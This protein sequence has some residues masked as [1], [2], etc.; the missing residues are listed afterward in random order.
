M[1]QCTYF[2]PTEEGLKICHCGYEMEYHTNSYIN[3]SNY[4]K[5]TNLKWEL[6]KH[7][8][9]EETNAFGEIEFDGHEGDM[10]PKFVRVDNNIDMSVIM[11]LMK[12]WG[13]KLPNLLISVAGDINAIPKKSNL[14]DGLMKAARKTDAWIITDGIQVSGMKNVTEPELTLKEN[15]IIGIAPWG[16]IHNRTALES[17]EGSWPAKYGTT[18]TCNS[19]ERFLDPDHS[20]YILVDDGTQHKLDIE[21]PFRMRLEREMV[22]MKTDTGN[23]VLI[24]TVVIGGGKATLRKIEQA[25]KQDTPVVV[26][27]GSG[28]AA[29]VL[30]YA[31]QNASMGD[32]DDSS[33]DGQDRHRNEKYMPKSLED[34]VGEKMKQKDISCKVKVIKSCLLK[35]G[36]IHI[37]DMDSDDYDIND[38]LLKAMM[39]VHRNSTKILRTQI[40]MNNNFTQIGSNII[41][42][43]EIMLNEI[44]FNAI[45]YERAD[46]VNKLI[47]EK[48]ELKTFFLTD[49]KLLKLYNNRRDPCFDLLIWSVLTNQQDKAK[50]FWSH[51]KNKLSA[52]L[53][54]HALFSALSRKTHDQ[55]LREAFDNN[56]SEFMTYA[57]KL[58]NS[59]YN[60]DKKKTYDLL[61][62]IVPEWDNTT[63]IEIAL[64][65][66]NEGFISLKVYRDLFNK[67]WMG[68]L[69]P[70]NS[71]M[72]NHSKTISHFRKV[73]SE[74]KAESNDKFDIAKKSSQPVKDTNSPEAS[75]FWKLKTFYNAPIII[76]MLNME[77]RNKLLGRN[78]WKLY[79]SSFEKHFHLCLCLLFMIGISLLTSNNEIAR[80]ILAIVFV[81]LFLR[82][83]HVFHLHRQVGPKLV[84]TINM[85]C[86]ANCSYNITL[87]GNGAVPRCP[88][89]TGQYVV[90]VMMGIYMMMTNILLI[91]LLIASF[92]YSIKKV[93][94]HKDLHC[95]T[96]RYKLIYEYYTKTCLPHPFAMLIILPEIYKVFLQLHLR[97]RAPDL[98]SSTR[99]RNAFFQAFDKD[100]D[101]EL[102]FFEDLHAMTVYQ[103]ME[104][105]REKHIDITTRHKRNR[106]K[107]S[108][109][110][111]HRCQIL[112]DKAD[113]SNQLKA[114]M[115]SLN[116]L[117]QY[118]LETK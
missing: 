81:L 34:R 14:R 57:N 30:A 9:T 79:N 73:C 117:K 24:V 115:A 20:H 86:E 68:G 67:I 45:K 26:V 59:C 83:L 1:R 107:V 4:D 116:E 105:T 64:N 27:K 95:S 12:H 99:R 28:G 112:K 33:N 46:I 49:E 92:S 40:I 72:M 15:V 5:Q 106:F 60:T 114:I 82:I 37:F 55:D 25:L 38:V 29:D 3:E 110:V 56:S 50:L 54:A 98:S 109:S 13:L 118:K 6:S 47:E 89:K 91:S 76:F 113:M 48:L 84:M 96:H 39:K 41:P 63:C 87:Y 58:A 80:V 88:T 75:I 42:P 8:E 43:D 74:L 66:H 69:K 31:Y 17:K 53:V 62:R 103:R 18:G 78:R 52:A 93:H 90:P 85:V 51:G 32:E 2:V 65:A 10:K 16:V 100:Y 35:S 11:E 22:Q 61:T 108:H 19:K 97:R 101:D 44:M 23:D 7:T 102:N 36:Q 21:I 71:I 104:Q 70:Q 94:Q 77:L 111:N